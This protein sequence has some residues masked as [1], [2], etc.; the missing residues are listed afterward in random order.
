MAR[1]SEFETEKLGDVGH[2]VD[3]PRLNGTAGAGRDSKEQ[4]TE[5]SPQQMERDRS[6]GRRQEQ[7]Q[8]SSP[9]LV[10]EDIDDGRDVEER[11]DVGTKD[12]R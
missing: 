3:D 7:R 12:W 9:A 1:E 8:D 4:K 2:P 6:I 11:V 5:R 10:D